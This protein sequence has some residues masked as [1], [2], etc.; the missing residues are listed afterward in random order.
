MGKQCRPRSDC[1]QIRLQTT[2]QTVV[3]SGRVFMLL[4][5][6]LLF[7]IADLLV[8]LFSSPEPKACWWAY[9]IGR[10]PL[11][12][13]CLP[14]SLN[15]FS[16]ET[17]GPIEAKFHMESPKDG[18]TK[19]CSNSPGHTHDQVGRHAHI[20]MVKTLKIFN[21]GTKRPMILKLGMQHQVLEYYQVCSN[22][23]P[24]LTLTYFTARS[25]LVPYAFIWEKK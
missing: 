8:R 12:V 13:I 19:V 24:G 1:S 7:G 5:I 21:S 2:D 17:T 10:P 18:G 9:R 14:H 3:W 4:L 6:N 22:D 23:V 20:V 15:I 16:S 25:N 11:S